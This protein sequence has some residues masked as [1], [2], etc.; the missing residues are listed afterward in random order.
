MKGALGKP[1]A[2][3]NSYFSQVKDNEAMQVLNAAQKW[4]TEKAIQGTPY[5]KLP[6]LSAA[7]PFKAGTRDN[8][9]YYTNIAAGTLELKNA[10]DLYLYDNNTLHAI[11]LT[12]AQLKEWLEMSAGQ[13]NQIKTD[14]KEEQNMINGDYRSYN[15]DVIDGVT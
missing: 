3:I 6:I 4:Y 12:G 5:E 2:P 14:T 15:F 13:F 7:A 1:T 10:A 8:P 11:V 9:N